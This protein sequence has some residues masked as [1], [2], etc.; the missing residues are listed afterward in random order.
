MFSK[1]LYRPKFCNPLMYD[2][3]KKSINETT[4]RMVE[5]YAEEKNRHN[6]NPKLVSTLMLCSDNNNDPPS[7]VLPIIC[8]LSITTFLLY[9]N[10]KY[11]L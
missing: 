7:T 8:F 10:R 11:V 3:C 9:F 6:L 5:K 2:F 1:F 4:R